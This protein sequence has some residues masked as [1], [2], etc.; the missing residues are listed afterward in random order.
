[1]NCGLSGNRG[2]RGWGGLAQKMRRVEEREEK[3]DGR[4]RQNEGNEKDE[5]EICKGLC[6][7][8]RGGF[9]F[10]FF[11]LD[12]IGR[13]LAPCERWSDNFRLG[14][15]NGGEGLGESC[16]SAEGGMEEKK[17]KVSYFIESVHHKTL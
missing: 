13:V 11:A 15:E 9:F 17:L 12:L 7:I 6:I 8:Y 16:G 2:T 5:S 3:E 1:M 4:K 14:R 10:S